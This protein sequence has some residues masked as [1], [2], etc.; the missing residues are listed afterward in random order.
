MLKGLAP[1]AAGPSP[2][3]APCCPPSPARGCGA[4]VWGC[5]GPCTLSALVGG[6]N[7]SKEAFLE[8]WQFSYIR[9][10]CLYMLLHTFLLPW[11]FLMIFVRLQS[12]NTQSGQRRQS[13]FSES[14][15]RGF[16]W[17]VRLNFEANLHLKGKNFDQEFKFLINKHKLKK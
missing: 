13:T 1:S 17:A 7:L 14:R 8:W 6:T 10:T 12:K 2:R 3:C 5:L 15:Q 11:N 16:W 4:G 9:A